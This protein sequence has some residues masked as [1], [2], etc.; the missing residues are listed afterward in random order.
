MTARAKVSKRAL[1]RVAF[2]EEQIL[3]GLKRHGARLMPGSWVDKDVNGKPCACAV[4][5]A[6]LSASEAFDG[7]RDY[8]MWSGAHEVITKAQELLD[9][10]ITE[11][12]LLHLEAGF[13]L[14]D[15]DN[16]HGNP[17][18]KANPFYLLGRKMRRRF[19]RT[20]SAHERQFER[21]TR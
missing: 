11:E 3:A 17:V 20:A 6:I 16:V 12:N 2:L 9:R 19:Y 15:H 10:G 4:G 5:A 7:T 14:R 8:L 13:E 1:A 18:D 21:S